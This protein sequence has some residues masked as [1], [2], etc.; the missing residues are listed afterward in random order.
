VFASEAE[1]SVI[2]NLKRKE[3]DAAKLGE[4]LARETGDAVRAE[5]IGARRTTN[6]YDPTVA[7]SVPAWLSSKED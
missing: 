1:G 5:I 7:M 3:A 2:A 4:E 6:A